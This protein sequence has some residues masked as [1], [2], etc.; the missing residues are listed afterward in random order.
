MKVDGKIKEETA[1]FFSYAISGQF[2]QWINN[3]LKED[4]EEIAEI[5]ERMLDGTILRIMKVNSK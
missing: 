5:I 2:L 4:K 3:G 1:V